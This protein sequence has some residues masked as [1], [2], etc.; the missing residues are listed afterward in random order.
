MAQI[1]FDFGSESK[2]YEALKGRRSSIIVVV[3]LQKFIFL[4]VLARDA[5]VRTNCRAIAM[6]FDRPSVW[7]GRAL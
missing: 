1:A 4:F 6:M 2:V 5:F 7:V 3:F